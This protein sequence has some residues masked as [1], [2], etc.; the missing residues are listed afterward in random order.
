MLALWKEYEANE[1]PEAR[2]VHDLDKVEMVLQALEYQQGKRTQ[3]HLEEFFQTS[4]PR[5][6]TDKGKE[7]WNEIRRRFLAL[8]E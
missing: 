7:L 2:F 4:E 6:Q 5:L 1:T 3:E 8:H